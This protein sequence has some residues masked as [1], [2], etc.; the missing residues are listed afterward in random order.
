MRERERRI[1]TR[2]RKTSREDRERSGEERK[3]GQRAKVAEHKEVLMR[4]DEGE[5]TSRRGA[6]GGRESERNE[7]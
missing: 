4:K 1:M 3:N 5:R 2:Q 7:E 6:R